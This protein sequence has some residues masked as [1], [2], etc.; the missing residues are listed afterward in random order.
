M[1]EL[2]SILSNATQSISKPYFHLSIDGGD[3]IYRERVYCYELYHQMRMIWPNNTEY[4]LNG[5]I[6]KAAHPIL[7]TLGASFIKP[8]LLIHKP[9]YMSGNQVIIEVKTQNVTTSGIRK[10][11]NSLTIFM[12]QVSYQRGIYLIYGY[13]IEPQIM[14]EKIQSVANEIENL[15]EIEIWFHL[16]D[17]FPAFHFN[18]LHK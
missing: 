17:A 16:Q 18:T 3:A 15:S 11:L 8:D 14:F 2:S 7:R 6:D 9:G 5:E 10:D 4:Y 12:N 1:E 13:D